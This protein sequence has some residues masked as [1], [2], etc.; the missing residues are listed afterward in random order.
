MEIITTETFDALFGK[1]NKTIQHKA[2]KKSDLFKENP[3]HPSLRVEKLHPKH[4]N[5]WSF[6]VDLHHRI[7]FRFL[8][9]ERVVFLYI[10][11]HR[12]IYDYALI[13]G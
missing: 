10:G 1:L 4:F 8:E 3:F 13:K 6:R 12:E 9:K 11:H 2:V 7:I 5:V